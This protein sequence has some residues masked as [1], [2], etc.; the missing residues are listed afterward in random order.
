[1]TRFSLRAAACAFF[2]ASLLAPGGA[3][4]F[5]PHALHVEQHTA[6]SPVRSTVVQ[7]EAHVQAPGHWG[8]VRSSGEV[9]HRTAIQ[10]AAPAKKNSVARGRR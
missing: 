10:P 4:A 1:M 2:V 6:Y 7:H 5:T 8:A 3:F 9:V